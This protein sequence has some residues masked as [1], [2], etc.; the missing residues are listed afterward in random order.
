MA[1]HSHGSPTSTSSRSRAARLWLFA[2]TACV[3]ACNATPPPESPKTPEAPSLATRY[4]A[5]TLVSV[6]DRVVQMRGCPTMG[7]ARSARTAGAC[8]AFHHA[9]RERDLVLSQHYRKWR[10]WCTGFFNQC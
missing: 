8:G 2:A 9:Y 1:R 3:T 6:G 5:V 4:A 7:P 10:C